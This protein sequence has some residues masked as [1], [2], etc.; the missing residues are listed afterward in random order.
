[1]LRNTL[2]TCFTVILAAAGYE[3]VIRTVRVEGTPRAVPEVGVALLLLAVALAAYLVIVFQRSLESPA[4]SKAA[5]V[6][7]GVGGAIGSIVFL[8]LL[9]GL[10]GHFMTSGSDAG[11]AATALKQLEIQQHQMQRLSHAQ[12]EIDAAEKTLAKMDAMEK[13]DALEKK[14]AAT[15]HAVTTA[16]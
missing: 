3:M 13:A 1:M 2:L 11:K 14:L 5:I 9:I 4:T 16:P 7:R 15:T 12:A 6:A 10:V 8:V